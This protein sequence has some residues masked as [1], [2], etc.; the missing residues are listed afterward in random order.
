MRQ[1]ICILNFHGIGTPH[2]GVGPDEA[3]YWVTR[4]QFLDTL[5]RAQVHSASGNPVRITFDDGNCSD[6]DVAA[7]ALRERG[8]SGDFFV[9]TGRLSDP[10]YLS[11]RDI[12][13]LHS[14]GMRIGLHGHDHVDWRKADDAQLKAETIT[15]REMLAQIVGQEID[16]VGIPFG[17]YNTRVVKQLKHAGFHEIYTSDGGLTSENCPLRHRTSIQGHMDASQIEAI[18]AGRDPLGRKI[19]RA[20]KAWMKS[21]LL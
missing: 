1:A 17:A 14:Q 7:P 12:K 13:A 15:A 8:L 19:N 4:D 16:T 5:D 21:N 11:K 18:L 3:R 9:L 20:L 6:L 2:E 10:R